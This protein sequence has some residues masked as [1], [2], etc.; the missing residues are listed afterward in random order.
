[1]R[2]CSQLKKNKNA[3]VKQLE[4]GIAKTK[5]FKTRE[6]ASKYLKDLLATNKRLKIAN[7]ACEAKREQPY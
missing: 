2:Q 5:I 4:R 3:S 1:L 7:C 6:N